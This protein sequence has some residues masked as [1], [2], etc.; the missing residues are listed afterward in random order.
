MISRIVK[1]HFSGSVH[2]GEGLLESSGESI[3]ADTLFSA[4]CHEVLLSGDENSFHDF[5]TETRKGSFRISDAFPFI[6]TECYIPKPVI[7]IQGTAE[8]DVN[9]SSVKK[10]LKKLRYLPVSAFQTYL[11]GDLTAK[12][13][14]EFNRSFQ[15]LGNAFLNAK[16]KT[17]A[18]PDEDSEPYFVGGF[19]F[20]PDCGLW[21]ILCAENNTLMEQY[22]SVISS[23]GYSGIGGKRSSGYGRFHID[24]EEIPDSLKGL[25]NFDQND[26]LMTLS[27]CLPTETELEKVTPAASYMLIRRSGF[28][29]SDT[30]ADKPQKK[31]DLYMFTAGSCFSSE[32]G[33]DLYDVSVNGNHPVYRYGFPLF[34]RLPK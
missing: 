11:Q 26:R 27:V 23:L 2:F 10:Q 6:K 28:T 24:S 20:Q 34:I 13:C 18:N 31:N 33:G 25:L 9:D 22:L 15:S 17:P 16:V 29:V 32:F 8:S 19:R 3:C 4:I 30:Y 5:I 7:G 12:Q 14:Q 1:M 21:F